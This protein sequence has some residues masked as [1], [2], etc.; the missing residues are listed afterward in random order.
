MITKFILAVV[1][2]TFLSCTKKSDEPGSTTLLLTQKTWILA[3][4]GTDHNHNGI[5]DGH[6]ESIRDC[7]KD[8][9][10]TFYTDGNG[11]MEDGILECGNGITEMPFTWKLVVNNTAIDFTISVAKILRLTEDELV[12]YHELSQGNATPLRFMTAFRH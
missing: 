8:N 2:L 6:E 5:I 11:L 3:S 4:I 12:I 1:F 10:Y 7:E 9:R